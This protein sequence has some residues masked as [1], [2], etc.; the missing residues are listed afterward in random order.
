[1]NAV[2]FWRFGVKALV[3]ASNKI[4]CSI[5]KLTFDEDH[6]VWVCLGCTEK[7]TNAIHSASKSPPAPKRDSISPR[8][9]SLHRPKS[10]SL[11]SI[12]NKDIALTL[13]IELIN[14]GTKRRFKY[15]PND[16]HQGIS[17]NAMKLNLLKR[18][19]HDIDFKRAPA[20]IC[21]FCVFELNDQQY[22]NEFVCLEAMSDFFDGA[23]IKI[24]VDEYY[25]NKYKIAQQTHK[26][27]KYSNRVRSKSLESSSVIQKHGKLDK[28]RGHELLSPVW[29]DNVC[30]FDVLDNL[31]DANDDADDDIKS[32]C[33]II[34]NGSGAIKCGL[35]GLLLSENHSG[36][37][38]PQPQCV[39][40]TIYAEN[41]NVAKIGHDALQFAEA[42]NLKITEPI[43]ADL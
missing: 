6:G 34:D 11:P 40:S 31:N 29:N 2:Q 10:A 19:H 16:L 32:E 25:W 9:H 23:K 33:I 26:N 42:E 41:S 38:N 21:D 12:N 17:L 20:E 30:G 4:D 22:R 36:S 18:F 35:G 39:F 24:K 3:M 5:C 13:F 28:M 1:M 27:G 15:K 14:N 43:N 8:F 37:H 7:L